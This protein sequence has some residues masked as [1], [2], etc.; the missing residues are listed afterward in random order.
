[1]H[2]LPSPL[3]KAP[4]GLAAAIATFAATLLIFIPASKAATNMLTNPGF[5]VGNASG[6]AAY[7]KHS[8]DS[9]REYY[10][11][12]GTN[13]PPFASNVL[14]HGGSRAGKAWGSF[15]GG[16]NV[17]GFYQDVPAVAGSVW[18]AAGYA[19]THQ[20]DLLQPG[21]RFW[22]EITFRDASDTI[23]AMY[24]SYI[25]DP[26]NTADLE[27]NI[28]H[29]LV[30]TNDYDIADATWKSITNSTDTLTAPAGSTKVRYQITFEQQKGFPAG[31]VWFDDLELNRVSTPEPQAAPA[32][33]VAPARPA[34]P[35]Q[36]I[37]QRG[38]SS[39]ASPAWLIA[40]ALFVIIGLLGWLVIIV[41]RSGLATARRPAFAANPALPSPREIPE[42]ADAAAGPSLPADMGTREK[43][44]SELT[45]FAKQS[46][47]QGLYSQRKE[48]A[49]TQLRAQQELAQLEARLS[50]LQ[51]PLQDRI[52]AYERRIAELEKELDTREGEMKELIH[53]T[54]LLVREQ[55]R[56]VQ[57]PG[58]GRFN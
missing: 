43:V 38:E 49:E 8:V 47:V 37:E 27:P 50:S 55:L 2:N 42:I 41:W 45:E 46:L 58:T 40:G 48:L 7:G 24:R 31:S 35:A 6:W 21:N 29:S 53:A 11:N 23:L 44:V 17:N 51:L 19:L 36:P 57:E 34:A 14:V 28:W 13:Y 12:G 52:Q 15:T 22:F 9:T 1:M 18:S 39:W 10:Y 32:P 26:T 30:V 5:E 25:L 20:Q 54:L 4:A 33:A 56:K 3:T 16:Y